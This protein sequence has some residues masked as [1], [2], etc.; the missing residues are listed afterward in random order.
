MTSNLEQNLALLN[1]DLHKSSSALLFTNQTYT[2][3]DASFG[4]LLVL[5]EAERLEATAVYFRRSKDSQVTLPQV[6]I[7]DNTHNKLNND[8]LV[9]IHRKLW[10]SD[11]VSV[12]YII[13]KTQIRIL[14]P[15]ALFNIKITNCL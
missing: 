6:F 11:I 4:E 7:Y 8:A 12:Y 5:Q 13:E 1:F 14:M 10:S 15:A 3:E 9:E 2:L